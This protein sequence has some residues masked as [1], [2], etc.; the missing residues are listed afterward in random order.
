M[1]GRA[2]CAFGG[3]VNGARCARGPY[4]ADA[5]A[6]LI[7]AALDIDIGRTIF[8]EYLALPVTVCVWITFQAKHIVSVR[9]AYAFWGAVMAARCARGLYAAV[10]NALLIAAAQGVGS[11]CASRLPYFPQG[12][13]VFVWFTCRVALGAVL[14]CSTPKR[15]WACGHQDVKPP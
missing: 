12:V 7:A 5:S 1:P 13:T 3:A 14:A 4:A 15:R 2:R 6:L 8:N 10:T 9:A 11:G